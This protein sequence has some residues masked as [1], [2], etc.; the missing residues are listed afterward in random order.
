MRAPYYDFCIYLLKKVGYLGLI[1]A[2]ESKKGGLQVCLGVAGI[3][4]MGFGKLVRGVW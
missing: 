2:Q 1:R 4:V 3:W